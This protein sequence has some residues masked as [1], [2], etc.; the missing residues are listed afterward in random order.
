[1]DPAIQ[2]HPREKHL[3]ELV[4]ARVPVVEKCSAVEGGVV[5][6]MV[7]PLGAVNPNRG[8]IEGY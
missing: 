1:M 5:W 4:Y 3:L 8:P 6:S 2:P 7:A